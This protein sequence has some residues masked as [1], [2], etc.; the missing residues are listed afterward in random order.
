MDEIAARAG[1][2][3][4]TLYRSFPTKDALLEEIV[5]ANIDAVAA[6]AVRA[7]AEERTAWIALGRVL[8]FIARLYS[9]TARC[10]VRRQDGELHRSGRGQETRALRAR[11]RAR[12]RG[13]VGR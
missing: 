3:V 9:A 13:A 10:L 8:R 12:R 2:G 4:R 6:E 1:V 11:W 5:V 7:G